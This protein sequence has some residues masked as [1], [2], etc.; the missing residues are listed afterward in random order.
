[1]RRAVFLDRDGVVNRAQTINGL[2]Q[3][4]K[5]LK[6][7]KIIAGARTGVR[8]LAELGFEIVV[9]TNQPDVSRGKTKLAAIQEIHRFIEKKAGIL[10]FYVCPHDD[11]DMCECRKPRPGLILRAASDLNLDLK[12]SYLIGDR[13]KDIE[14]GNSVG[15]TTIFIDYG[16]LEPK[17]KPPYLSASSL[18]QAAKTIKEMESGKQL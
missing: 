4:P 6:D 5:E 8:L 11:A 2:P 7:L 18:L 15:C 17:P 14:A 10:K 9:V 3:S 12:S 1:M 13:W 16:Y